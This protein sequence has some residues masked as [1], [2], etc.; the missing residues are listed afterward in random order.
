MLT[1]AAIQHLS[2]ESR[3]L[4]AIID[5]VGPYRPIITRDPFKALVGSIVQQQISMSAAAAIQAR[6]RAACGGAVTPDSILGRRPAQLRKAGLSAQKA[7]YLHDLSAHFADGRLSGSKLRRMDDEA[8]IAATC[9][10]H[11]IGRWTAE[12]LLIF[13]LE[14]ADV[15]PIDD[16]G[17][18]KAVRNVWGHK[19]IPGKDELRAIGQPWRPYRTYASWYLWRS[20]EGPLMP[21]IRI[22]A[23]N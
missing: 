2:T 11:G 10:V 6:L 8:V 16:L 18:R 5:R 4:A 9:A 21:G 3:E 22:E 1:H 17:I 15:W 7:A 23:A 13:C 12:M 20:L 19:E 14:R